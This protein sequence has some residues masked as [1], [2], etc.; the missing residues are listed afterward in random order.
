MREKKTKIKKVLKN[1]SRSIHNFNY[2]QS[3]LPKCRRHQT[4]TGDISPPI[5]EK[6]AYALPDLT[7]Q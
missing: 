3:L 7:F 4:V 2:T 5:G 6:A 1:G